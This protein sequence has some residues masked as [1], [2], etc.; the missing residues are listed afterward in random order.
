M[1]DRPDDQRPD[2]D[3]PDREQPDEEMA[4]EHADELAS[5]YLDG[6]ASAAERARVESDPELRRRVD[7]LRRASA[8][9]GRPVSPAVGRGSRHGDPAR[10]R[11][12]RR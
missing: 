5:A 11:G 6:E 10:S 7:E 4:D 9:V 8:L 3:Q 1:T 2:G 12:R